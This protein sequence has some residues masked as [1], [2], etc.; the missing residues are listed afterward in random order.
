MRRSI[1][2]LLLAVALFIPS[3]SA[4][5]QILPL[6]NH[7]KVYDTQPLTYVVPLQLRD[8]FGL[9]AVDDLIL[10]KFANPVDKNG[11]GMVD[12]LIH[13]TWWKVALEAP[14]RTVTATDQF[15]TNDWIVFN[16]SYLVLPAIKN[17]TPSDLPPP[18]N[19]YLC[20]DAVGPSPDVEVTLA[21]Q[22]GTLITIV[23]NGKYF[24]NPVEK[25][26]PTGDFY[27]IIDPEAHLTCYQIDDPNPYGLDV[28][29]T[30]QFG[31]WN[32]NIGSSRCL[33]TPA[34]KEG[35]VGTEESTW[36]RIK[37]LYR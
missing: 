31:F 10:E 26:H 11:E 16:P 37:G 24:C 5:A 9:Y 32:L 18:W 28:T 13:Q 34:F 25:T 15:G 33:C 17:G 2:A 19:H 14:V 7:Y 30:D 8:Q 21:D 29:A 12:P 36:G 27:P 22:F 35:V 23:L 6:E 1:C 4:D 3:A 20:Y